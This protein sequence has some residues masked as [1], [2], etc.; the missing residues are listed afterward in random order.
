MNSLTKQRYIS[1]SIWSDDWF[2]SLTVREKLFYFWLLTN[3]HTNPAGV[4]PCTLRDIRADFGI[5]REEA[6]ELLAKFAGA[7]KAFYFREHIVIPK[8][9]KHQKFG[10]RNGLFLGAVKTLRALPDE[11]KVFIADRAHY[12]FDVRQYIDIPGENGAD[13]THAEKEGATPSNRAENR[14]GTPENSNEN[15]HDLDLDPDSD[16]DPD[17]E[18]KTQTG[19]APPV[20]VKNPAAALFI[21]LWQS[22]SDIFNP[23]AAFRKPKDWAAFWGRSPPSAEQIT[24]AV[25]N[26]VAGIKC[27]AIERRFIPGTPDTFILNGWVQRMQE[28]ARANGGRKISSDRV[29]EGKAD[30]YFREITGKGG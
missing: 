7:G 10:N 19:G 4:Y 6:G 21:R 30:K 27:G 2:D 12:D 14:G 18:N 20:N 28:P 29:P 25:D 23:V 26:F 15:R 24:R 22:H 9:M 13:D 3:Q 17:S 1:S 11:V 8:W 5:S 16:P